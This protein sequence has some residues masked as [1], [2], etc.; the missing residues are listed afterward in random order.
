MRRC[1][2]KGCDKQYRPNKAAQRYCSPEC[3][4]AARQ[5][6][7]WKA[8][9]K[10]RDTQAGKEKR[11]AQCRRNRERV[12]SRKKRALNDSSENARVITLNF[13]RWL[14]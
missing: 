5:W 7:F 13:F 12:K 9:Q 8:Q 4:Q 10:Y 2:L 14:L 6:S 3:R 11:Q 1:L